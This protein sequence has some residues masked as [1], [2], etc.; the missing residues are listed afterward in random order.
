MGKYDEARAKQILESAADFLAPDLEARRDA[1]REL[2]KELGQLAGFT[3]IRTAVGESKA[4]LAI[5]E[6]AVTIHFT[7][8]TWE[9]IPEGGAPTTV[10]LA[11]DPHDRKFVGDAL[12]GKDGLTVLLE[13]ATESMKNRR[14]AQAVQR[15]L[16]G[17]GDQARHH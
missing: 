12:D 7:G 10:A 1:A 6:H 9:V 5:G 8:M 15:S 3:R 17:I 2:I 11:F 14:Q 16:G 4:K 13:A